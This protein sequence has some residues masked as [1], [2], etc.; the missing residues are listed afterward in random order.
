M[1]S[2]FL[3]AAHWGVVSLLVILAATLPYLNS[4]HGRY[5]YDDKVR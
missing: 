1:G 5:V 2:P 4:L 3:G